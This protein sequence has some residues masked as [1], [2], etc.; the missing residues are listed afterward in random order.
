MFRH[1]NKLLPDIFSDFYTVNKD[2]THRN[3]RQCNL[4]HKFHS[5]CLQRSMSIRVTGIAYYNYF[6][7]KI[8][9]MNVTYPTYK[10]HIKNYL[11]ANVVPKL[12]R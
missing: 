4:L 12:Y 2:T 7:E 5:K 11:L 8:S 10:G 9:M 6:Y 1:K 3:T